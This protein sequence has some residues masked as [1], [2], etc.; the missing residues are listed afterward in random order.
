MDQ[1]LTLPPLQASE[2]RCLIQWKNPDLEP[3]EPGLDPSSV[4]I[5]SMTSGKQ[6][7]LSEP[8][9]PRPS[10]G[11][12]LSCVRRI[13]TP[14]TIAPRR[15]CPWDSPG[16]NTGV[17]SHSLLQGIFPPRDQTRSPALQ[18]VYPLRH[19]GSPSKPTMGAEPWRG[20]GGTSGEK[21]SAQHLARSRP[22][23]GFPGSVWY[24]ERESRLTQEKAA[25]RGLLLHGEEFCE[26]PGL[27]GSFSLWG[28]APG[29]CGADSQGL[30]GA[31]GWRVAPPGVQRGRAGAE[32]RPPPRGARSPE[33]PREGGS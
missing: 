33:Q 24:R 14:R 20:L 11:K 21:H 9:F 22:A 32:P 19:Q 26:S 5:S 15:L 18:A 30:S 28:Q 31:G 2:G 25:G 7:G 4:L 3:K 10:E 8:Q 17:G 29:R 1:L 23:A 13:V 27:R 12:S 16:K 6:P